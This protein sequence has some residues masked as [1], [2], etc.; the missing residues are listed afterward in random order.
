MYR[1]TIVW[2]IDG[3]WGM[4]DRAAPHAPAINLSDAQLN[5]LH[6]PIC[7]VIQLIL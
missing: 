5:V 3:M 7:Y 4:D 2:C 1:S 6:V